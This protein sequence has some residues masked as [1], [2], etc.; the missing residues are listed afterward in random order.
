MSAHRAP[1]PFEQSVYEAC[2]LIPSGRVTTYGVLAKLLHSA[3]RAVGQA[4]KRNPFAPGVP[5]HRVITTSL[6]IGGF[7]GS[8]GATEAKVQTK[9][10]MLGEEG[11]QFDDRGK[12]TSD[13]SAVMGVSEFCAGS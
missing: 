5:C 1:T 3:P 7:Q 8:W 10:A 2:R 13:P 6:N 12:L 4:L 9:T 11:L